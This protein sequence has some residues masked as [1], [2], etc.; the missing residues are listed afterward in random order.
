VHS[1]YIARSISL[2]FIGDEKALILAISQCKVSSGNIY[3][4]VDNG[5][6]LHSRA[7]NLHI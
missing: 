4:W 7:Q 2:V 5:P 1:C 3:M 6:R